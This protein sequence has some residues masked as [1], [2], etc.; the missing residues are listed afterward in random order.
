M[1]TTSFVVV[2]VLS[3]IAFLA[4]CGPRTHSVPAY[5]WQKIAKGYAWLEAAPAYDDAD[6]VWV[7]RYN[8]NVEG[9][10]GPKTYTDGPQRPS[11]RIQWVRIW[12][13]TEFP[14]LHSMDEIAKRAQEP[15]D[16]Y[17][18]YFDLTGQALT[19]DNAIRPDMIREYVLNNEMPPASVRRTFKFLK[20][21]EVDTF[22]EAVVEKASQ[23]YVKDGLAYQEDEAVALLERDADVR[24]NGGYI[25][26]IRLCI[27]LDR[28]NPM[29]ATILADQAKV[30]RLAELV[31]DFYQ[32]Y[33]LDLPGG[34]NDQDPPFGHRH[35][36][37][38]EPGRTAQRFFPSNEY[39]ESA[40][41]FMS[42]VVLN[43]SVNLFAYVLPRLNTWAE[44]MGAGKQI[45]TTWERNTYG[46]PRD[47]QPLIGDLAFG[48]YAVPRRDLASFG[49][50]M[51]A[52]GPRDPYRYF[53]PDDVADGVK[54]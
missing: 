25:P 5:D 2:G 47:F 9:S 40:P 31:F 14:G 36:A 33:P 15:K 8:G 21:E 20:F 18:W 28:E 10:K 13:A 4:G 16:T 41:R 3:A 6:D 50:T 1:R 43:T 51:A 38:L 27:G 44:E 52:K 19:R 45:F 35:M 39:R 48:I 29:T 46:T 37:M 24:A 7:S 17:P 23:K 30:D 42:P 32:R 26:V 12:V 49:K 34:F 22:D 11:D 54:R 53:G